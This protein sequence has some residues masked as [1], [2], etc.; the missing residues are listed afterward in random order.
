MVQ[1]PDARSSGGK[2]KFKM[3]SEKTTAGTKSNRR[4]SEFICVLKSKCTPQIEGFKKCI[5]AMYRVLG[6]GFNSWLWA[7]TEPSPKR[8]FT[9]VNKSTFKSI[10]CEVCVTNYSHVDFSLKTDVS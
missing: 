1:P 5:S 9:A 8:R 10:T 3:Y 7:E 6:P 2:K 4:H